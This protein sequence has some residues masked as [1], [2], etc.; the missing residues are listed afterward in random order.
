MV[1]TVLTIGGTLLAVSLVAGTLILFQIQQAG[2]A[3][4]SAKALFAADSGVGFYLKNQAS[5]P[6]GTTY[7]SLSGGA[8]LPAFL[9]ENKAT[10][11]IEAIAD[12]QA[13]IIGQSGN[14]KR[15]FLITTEAATQP[16]S[17]SDE[18]DV[19]FV[20]SRPSSNANRDILRDWLRDFVNKLETDAPGDTLVR[21]R[22]G[23]V[24]YNQ[25]SSSVRRNFTNQKFDIL[26]AISNIPT[27]VDSSAHLFGGLLSA[28]LLINTADTIPDF[29]VIFLDR[30]PNVA[31]ESNIRNRINQL[32][33]D[34]VTIIYVTPDGV[35]DAT[36]LSD[37]AS[38]PDLFFDPDYP[39]LFNPPDLNPDL[40]APCP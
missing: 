24:D 14:S 27:S 10:F 12:L 38:D 1:L 20:I 39:D 40:V 31:S 19:M 37:I 2:S 33:N 7:D 8:G 22:I 17:C 29:M 36:N 11:E 25:R 21:N 5:F 28:G 13:K 35:S 18:F 3:A 26:T 16:L 30:N 32:K 4:D 23:I 6:M 15:A 34:G 9:F